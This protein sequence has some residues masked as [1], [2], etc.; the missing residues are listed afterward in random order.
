LM[1]KARHYECYEN[2]K[3]MR[4]LPKNLKEYSAA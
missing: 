1:E 3:G 4:C 2:D